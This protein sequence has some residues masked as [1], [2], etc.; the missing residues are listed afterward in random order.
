M[1]RALKQTRFA[2]DLKIST[3]SR[4]ADRVWHLDGIRPATAPG[5]FSL[6]WAFEIGGR[7]FTDAKWGSWCAAAKTFLWSLKGDPPPGRR[8]VHESTLVS[9]FKTMRVLI[10]WMASQGYRSFTEL[11][12]EASERF[13]GQLAQRPG[14]RSPSLTPTTQQSYRNLLMALYLQGARY[15]ELRIDDPFPGA[16]RGRTK[17]HT[18]GLPFTP[19]PIAVALVSAAL[20]LIGTPADEILALSDHAQ[21]AYDESLGRNLTPTQASFVVVN[22]LAGWRFSTLSGESTPWHPEPIKSTK[23]V[24]QL[25]DRLYEACFVVVAYLIGARVSEIVGLKVGCVEHHRSAADGES[26][27]YLVGSIYKTAPEPEGEV[28]RW[29][30]PPAVER[31]VAVMERLSKPLRQRAGRE[32]LWLI[33]SSSGLLGPAARITLPTSG[34]IGTR[35]NRSF[36]PYID[37]PLHQ[38]KPWRLA[39]HQ[40]R[41]TFARFVGKRDRTGLYALQAHFGHVSRVMTD[42]GYVGT[43]FAL[44]ELIDRQAQEE[45][46]AALEELLTATSLGGKSGR[47]IAARS[48]FRGRTHSG[49]IKAYVEFLMSETDLRLG[50]CDWGY[51]VYRMEASACAGNEKG[52]NPVLR[53]ESVCISCANFAVTDKHRPVWEARRARHVELLKQAALDAQSRAVTEARIAE[54]DRLL[55]Q[56][57][58][59]GTA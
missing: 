10:R 9:T 53:T 54:C 50:T 3:R 7:C 4:L 24:R 27:A 51:C 2:A 14:K 58:V 45:T 11:D 28:H 5:E 18:A 23:A 34:T 46:R 49:E 22:A 30:A 55:A 17:P 13:M 47:L 43:D 39:T 56:L 31:A 52:P 20:R 26:F 57:D 25:I 8:A 15:P 32:E 1:N 42:Q 44:N 16:G 21:S 59:G 36:A 48:R 33:S 40:G 29:V 41:K 35:L 38:G 19:D 37:L 6:N 12:R